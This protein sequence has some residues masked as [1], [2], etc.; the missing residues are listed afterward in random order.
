MDLVQK[1]MIFALLI[2][3]FIKDLREQLDINVTFGEAFR[4]QEQADIYAKTGQGISNSLHR[5]R[6]AIDLNLFYAG[7]LLKTNEDHLEAGVLWE[8]Y[9][10]GEC[11]TVWGGRFEKP[12]SDHFSLEHNGVR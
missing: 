8:S 7:N 6:L 11:K 1:Q 10:F 5:L 9:A 4:T 2:S 3:R 12:D